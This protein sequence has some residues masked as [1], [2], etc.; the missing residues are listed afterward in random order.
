LKIFGEVASVFCPSAAHQAKDSRLRQIYGSCQPSMI[1]EL[2]APFE[3]LIRTAIG[4]MTYVRT[5]SGGKRI[6]FR[7]LK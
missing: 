6:F 3:R 7:S 4:L 5:T 2:K 1:R